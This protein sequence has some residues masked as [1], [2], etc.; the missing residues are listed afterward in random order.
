MLY[1]KFTRN[2]ERFTTNAAGS[3]QNAKGFARNAEQFNSL[4]LLSIRFSH[5][6]VCSHL[7]AFNWILLEF[8]SDRKNCF[9]M[10]QNNRNTDI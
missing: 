6:V 9:K 4:T 7:H 1:I 3:A 5:L 8:S 2:A 10:A